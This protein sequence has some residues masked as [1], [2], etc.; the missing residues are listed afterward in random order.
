MTSG[1]VLDELH[2]YGARSP[3]LLPGLLARQQG[4]PGIGED[5]VGAHDR[6][7][8]DREVEGLLSASR[9]VVD[10]VG[11]PDGAHTGAQMG[12]AHRN[13]AG[14]TAVVVGIGQS[15]VGVGVGR[16]QEAGEGKQRG[17]RDRRRA[18]LSARGHGLRGR[19]GGVA[20]GDVLHVRAGGR[21]RL[22]VGDDVGRD[23]CRRRRDASAELGHGK[24]HGYRNRHCGDADGTGKQHPGSGEPHD[25]TSS[26]VLSPARQTSPISPMWSRME[27]LVPL[28]DSGRSITRGLRGHNSC[29][30]TFSGLRSATGERTTRPR[31]R[32]PSRRATPTTPPPRRR[33]QKQLGSFVSEW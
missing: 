21:R 18:A 30:T 11:R 23:R 13:R 8:P 9:R 28:V 5:P 27:A 33:L 25:M 4:D 10:L 6:V 3:V 14:G 19:V 17:P 26:L 12:G 1:E 29:V 15:R 24:R 2:G 16:V 31:P 32:R 7:G 22:V 20:C